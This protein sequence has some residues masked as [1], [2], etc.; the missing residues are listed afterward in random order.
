MRLSGLL[1]P[2]TNAAY[3]GSILSAWFLGLSAVGSLVPGLIHYGL[4]DGGAGTIAGI[5]LSTRRETIVAVFAWYGALQ[6]PHGLA[7]L[8]VALRYRSLVP[9][10]LLLVILERGLVAL[11]GWF[12]RGAGDHHPPEHY[13]TVAQAALAV[14]FL[15]L[16]LRPR[17]VVTP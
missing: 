6:I 9:L 5:D 11:D 15:L 12:G 8:A 17:K 7:Q 3:G 16:S 4:P 13:T 1:P 10:L 14:L 2:S